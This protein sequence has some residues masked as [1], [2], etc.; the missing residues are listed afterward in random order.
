MSLVLFHKTG[1]ILSF[2]MSPFGG[3]WAVREREGGQVRIEKR[4]KKAN[5]Y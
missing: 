3:A 1:L 4:W 2:V 5:I